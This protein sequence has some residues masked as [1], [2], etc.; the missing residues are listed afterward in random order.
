VDY[1]SLIN[2][3]VDQILMQSKRP[4]LVGITGDS[5]SGK[6]Y[7]SKSIQK[8]LEKRH[9]PYIHV[10]HDDFLIP[11][12]DREPMKNQ[13]Y[14]EGEFKGKSKWEI[15]ENMFYLD[16]FKKVIEDLNHSKKTTYYPYKRET[17]DLSN[18]LKTIEPKDI[19]IFDS[20]MMTEY[21]DFVIIIDVSQEIIIKRKLV[22]DHDVRTPEQIID[23]HKRVQGYYWIRKKPNN[24]NIII[25]NNDYA[26]PEII[27]KNLQA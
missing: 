11:R 16:K 20:S 9:I 24:A 5:G 3:C 4:L 2:Y 10:D 21:M 23:M 26:H 25:N 17:G 6:S 22:R 18:K 8:E 7:F 12:K 27:K 1:S 19:I 15:L 14:T 13:F